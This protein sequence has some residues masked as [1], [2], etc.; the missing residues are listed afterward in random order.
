MVFPRSIAKM[1]RSVLLLLLMYFGFFLSVR[2]T[3]FVSRMLGFYY[4]TADGG[5]KHR[6]ALENSPGTG[7]TRVDISAKKSCVRACWVLALHV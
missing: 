5:E 2:T 4:L 3:F 7:D 6:S 1:L